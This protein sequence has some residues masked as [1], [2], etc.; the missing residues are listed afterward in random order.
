M[1]RLE[2]QFKMINP[3]LTAPADG[4]DSIEGAVW[5]INQKLAQ[6]QS[7]SCVYGKKQGSSKRY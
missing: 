1:T 4:P 5:I 6:L 2:D 7:D 3:K